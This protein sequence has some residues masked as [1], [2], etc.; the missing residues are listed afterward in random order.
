MVEA[1]VLEGLSLAGVDADPEKV[2]TILGNGVKFLAAAE[3]DN[4]GRTNRSI[5]ARGD[6][7]A[8]TVIGPEHLQLIRTEKLL[9][10]GLHPRHVA[11]IVGHRLAADVPDGE[12][13]RWN[14]LMS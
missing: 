14:D 1:E 3:R 13:I 6:L 8:G 2:K 4:Y 12:G 5:H 9:R 7:A 11:Q 10:P